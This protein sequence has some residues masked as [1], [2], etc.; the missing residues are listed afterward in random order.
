LSVQRNKKERN[1][2]ERSKEERNKREVE[3]KFFMVW[4]KRNR[5]EDE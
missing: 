4:M 3:Y 1:R 5:V 2:K